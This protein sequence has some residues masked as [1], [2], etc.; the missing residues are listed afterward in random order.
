[1]HV[2]DQRMSFQIDHLE[3]SM[4]VMASAT[5]SPMMLEIPAGNNAHRI[6]LVERADDL[7]EAA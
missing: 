1:M 6:R 7:P 2:A 5:M 4:P 3:K